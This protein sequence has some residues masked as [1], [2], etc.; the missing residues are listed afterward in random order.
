MANLP[1]LNHKE[2]VERY[3]A[4][5]EKKNVDFKGCKHKEVSFFQDKHELR[6]VCGASWTG[7]RL[8]ELYKALTKNSL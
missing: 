2:D 6:C 3:E 5:E 4:Y 8:H 1:P 7:A